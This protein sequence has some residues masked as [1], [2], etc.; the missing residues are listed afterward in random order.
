MP[1]HPIRL[2]LVDDHSVVR[3]GLG[4]VLSLY[5]ELKVVAEAEDGA[6]A[7]ETFRRERPDVVLMDAR[8]PGTGGAEALRAIRQEF[9]TARAIMLTTSDLDEDVQ[10]AIEAGANGYLLKNVGRDEL[11]DAIK[12]VHAGQQYIPAAIR[13][14]MAGL[15]SRKHLSAREIEVLDGMRRGL[16]NREIAVA[17][18]ISEHTA[19]AHVKA[20]LHKLESADRAEAVAR[21]FEQGLLRVSDR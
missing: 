19:K 9:P 6:E 12:Q 3:M 8:M 10:Q 5:P 4:A 14:L 20:I 7:V 16:S 17:L 18:S 1:P 15:A 2:M 11:V 13:K 21:A